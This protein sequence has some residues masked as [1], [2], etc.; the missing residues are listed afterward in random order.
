MTTAWAF[1]ILRGQTI[2][3]WDVLYT[4]ATETGIIYAYQGQY[5]TATGKSIDV[6]QLDV[7]E[8]DKRDSER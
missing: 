1:Y 5:T 6:A 3:D 2:V 7:N 4:S 8:P